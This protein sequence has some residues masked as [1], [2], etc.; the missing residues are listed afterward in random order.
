VKI[1]LKKSYKNIII[2]SLFI[3]GGCLQ[4]Q[5]LS[6]EKNIKNND[7]DS[8]KIGYDRVA[9]ARHESITD[10]FYDEILNGNRDTSFSNG[11]NGVIN[12]FGAPLEES[13]I[14]TSFDFETAEIVEIHELIY[15]DFVHRYYVSKSGHKLYSGFFI[16]KKLDRLKSVNIGDTSEKL[17]ST[18]TDKYYTWLEYERI[19]ENISYYTDPVVCE[20]QFVIENSIIQKIWC[21]FLLI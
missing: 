9:T 10:F 13:K 11:E 20:I 6:D 19:K 1:F 2:I 14:P 12:F 17:A 5:E 8:I 4:K 7:S 15:D 3:L 16:T 18:F 21:N